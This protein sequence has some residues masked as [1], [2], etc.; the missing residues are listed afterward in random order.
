MKCFFGIFYLDLICR[1]QIK[2][3]KNNYILANE[4]KYH[5]SQGALLTPF[6]KSR[7]QPQPKVNPKTIVVLGILKY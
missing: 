5:Y 3:L 7:L 4:S 6:P 2:Y 1:E